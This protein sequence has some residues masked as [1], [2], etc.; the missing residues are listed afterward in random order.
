MHIPVHSGTRCF[1]AILT[2]SV[3]GVS[4]GHVTRINGRPIAQ[5]SRL[6]AG[7]SDH[8]AAGAL[9]G[10][11]DGCAVSALLRRCSTTDKTMTRCFEDDRAVF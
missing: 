4:P 11:L 7:R 8:L 10:T 3:V 1:L 9:I 5:W 2:D 6:Q